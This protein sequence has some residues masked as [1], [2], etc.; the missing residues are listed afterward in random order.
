MASDTKNVKIGVCKTYFDGVD[1]GYTKGGVEVSVSTDT[2]KVEVDQFGKTPI[3]EYIMGRQLKV[4]VPLAE[5]TLENMVAIM[6]GATLTQT[7][8]TVASGTITFATAAAAANDTVT[9]NGAVFTFKA[10]PANEYEVLPGATFG[11]SAANLQAALAASTDPRVAQA[12]YSVNAGV[13]TVKY[14]SELQYGT[15]GKQGVVGNSFTLAK[16]GVNT[17]VSGATLTG[18]VDPTSTKIS[19]SNGVGVDLLSL[20]RELRLHPQAKAD[21]DKADDF[22][23]PLAATPGALTFAYQLENERVYNVEFS[24][25]P[26]AN[27]KLYQVGV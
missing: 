20:A 16:S 1:L 2:H 27:G 23:I 12:T 5:S 7:G 3:N 15:D 19:V 22:I 17:T 9:V 4:K 21:T 24:G 11:A 13:V 18:G 25:Y 8:G 6:P 14:G 26:D 10:V